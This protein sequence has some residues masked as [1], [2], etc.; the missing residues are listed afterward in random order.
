MKD[1]QS[2]V[3]WTPIEWITTDAATEAGKEAFKVFASGLW[4]LL[5]RRLQGVAWAVLMEVT[6]AI[7]LCQE[8]L[9]KM[10]FSDGRS[11]VV[12]GANEFVHRSPYYSLNSQCRQWR[13]AGRGIPWRRR[14]DHCTLLLG[15]WQRG[16]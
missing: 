14:H 15:A 7:L 4:G 10:S 1:G 2:L 8:S 12:K 3:E 13:G 5:S 6:A 11:M 16:P 9:L